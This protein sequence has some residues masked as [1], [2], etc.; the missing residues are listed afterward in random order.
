MNDRKEPF[1]DYLERTLDVL[2][3]MADEETY[4]EMDQLWQELTERETH[5]LDQL[6]EHFQVR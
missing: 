4:E 1:H 2:N 5:I 3:K 6:C